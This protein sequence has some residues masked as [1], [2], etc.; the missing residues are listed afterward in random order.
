MILVFLIMLFNGDVDVWMQHCWYGNGA[1]IAVC[2]DPHSDIQIDF[3]GDG[4]DLA[5]M[6]VIDNGEVIADGWSNAFSN[7]CGWDF[8]VA[9]EFSGEM[10]EIEPDAN[11][12]TVSATPLM[13]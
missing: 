7:P 4:S 12:T 5:Q 8:S 2:S 1:V 10:V 11:C 9:G 3:K 6:T 13:D